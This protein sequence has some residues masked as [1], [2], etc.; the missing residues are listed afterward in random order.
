MPKTDAKK[1]ITRLL[2]GLIEKQAIE[3][4]KADG[5]V[6]LEC[7]KIDRLRKQ[8][9][10]IEDASCTAINLLEYHGGTKKP[11]MAKKKKRRL[12]KA[13]KKAIKRQIIGYK[14]PMGKPLEI[15]TT[16]TRAEKISEHMRAYWKK[17]KAEEA[18]EPEDTDESTDDGTDEGEKKET[19]ADTIVDDAAKAKIKANMARLDKL[20][21]EVQGE[22]K[23]A[24]SFNAQKIFGAMK[25][26]AQKRIDIQLNSEVSFGSMTPALNELLEKKLIKKTDYGVYALIE[27]KENGKYS[28]ERE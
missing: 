22:I 5:M 26:G 4:H 15:V 17:R 1:E 20:Q 11:R 3:E 19:V 13:S 14:K 28:K 10:A 7:K 24:L 23:E 2:G 16:K 6:L 21:K 25:K 27:E 18:G 9:I 12:K 8:L